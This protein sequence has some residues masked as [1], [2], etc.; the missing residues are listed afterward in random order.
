G[1]VSTLPD[2]RPNTGF[3]ARA[4]GRTVVLLRWL[5]VPAWIAAAAI[6]F[7]ALPGI[8]GLESAP[9]SG[10]VPGGSP[11][12]QAQVRS[13]QLFRVPIVSGLVVVARKESGFS[14]AEQQ[15]IVAFAQQ[16]RQ[17]NG[18]VAVPVIN[19]LGLVPG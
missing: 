12:M 13:R 18:T 7:V 15:K 6:A 9:L 16:A 1:P 2:L 4:F 11:A 17:A 5:I 10:L 8:T 14:L 3:A 19:T